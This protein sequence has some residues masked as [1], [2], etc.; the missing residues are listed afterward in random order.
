MITVYKPLKE[1]IDLYHKSLESLIQ[2]NMNDSI[3]MFET[4]VI[5]QKIYPKIYGQTFYC[6]VSDLE[7]TK[8]IS[9]VVNATKYHGKLN[10]NDVIKVLGSFQ[11]Y[12]KKDSDEIYVRLLAESITKCESTN[13]NNVGK[14]LIEHIKTHPIKPTPFPLKRN[15]NLYIIIPKSI[16]AKSTSDVMSK[17]KNPIYSDILNI[18]EAPCDMMNISE[19]IRAVR[20]A[21][22]DIDVIAI[23]RGGSSNNGVDISLFDNIELYDAISNLYIHRTIG[24]GHT[25]DRLLLEMT[26]DYA[27]QTPL[28]LADYIISKL[29]RNQNYYHAI[30]EGV[31]AYQVI[32]EKN[33]KIALLEAKIAENKSQEHPESSINLSLYQNEIEIL[34]QQ[35]EDATKSNYKLINDLKQISI[36]SKYS[37]NRNDTNENDIISQITKGRAENEELKRINATLVEKSKQQKMTSNQVITYLILVAIVLCIFLYLKW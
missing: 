30:D 7:E 8:Q 32:I 12:Q 37:S 35:L 25:N 20:N 11:L 22:S 4:E 15:I 16:D 23:T 17:L 1:L 13:K 18:I 5:I 31:K 26:I 21:P 19:I 9:L 28:S 33:E 14:S 27:A 29:E 10:I 2:S 36:N 34:K 24:I 6:V 3:F